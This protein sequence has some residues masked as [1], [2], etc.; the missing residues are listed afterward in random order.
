MNLTVK[1]RQVEY[2][3]HCQE[4]TLVDVAIFCN[5]TTIHRFYYS[6]VVIDCNTTY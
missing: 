4:S 3:L 2:D 1:K 6:V 5:N